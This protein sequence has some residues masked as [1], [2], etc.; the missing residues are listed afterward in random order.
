[1]AT[2]LETN[3]RDHYARYNAHDME[4]FLDMHTDDILLEVVLADTT[5][6]RGKQEAA[7]FVN[8]Y[9]TAF[10]DIKMELTSFFA[11][12]NRVCEESVISGTHKGTFQGI[13]A[14]GKSFAVRCVLIRELKEGKT[15]RVS[16]YYDS[17]SVMKQLGFSLQSPQK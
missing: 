6:A 10:P 13:P 17:A 7:S 11:S 15:S 4:K 2:D 5:I 8:S 12:G 1:M 3:I 9:F 14:T 16:L